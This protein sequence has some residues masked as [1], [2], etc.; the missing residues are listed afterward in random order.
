MEKFS[1]KSL[2]ALGD[3]YVYGLID[4][5]DKKLF[6][7]GK[8][9]GNRV[10]N[11]EKESKTS[12]VSDKLKL[13]KITEIIESG[14]EVEK[15]IIN[16][17]LTE[18][19]AYAAEAALINAFNYVSNIGLTNISSGHHSTEAMTVERFERE[20]GAEILSESDI[21]HKI[22]VI[23]INKLYDRN[24]TREE[25]YDAVRGSWN[26]SLMRAKQVDYVFG[27]FNSL[28]VGVYKPTQW[29]VCKDAIDKLPRQE[30]GLNDRIKNRIFFVDEAF[31][32]G[33]PMDEAEMSYL[34][35]SISELKYNQKSQNPITY[36]NPL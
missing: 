7:I 18:A 4:P 5:R 31:E 11:H 10:F 20:Y 1:E 32:N 9:T 12:P 16:S 24:M 3:Y 27:V 15:I 28:I 33:E 30:D 34:Y 25:L 23:K 36:L 35:K 2:L 19:E 8:G 17:N 21:K 26:A 22:L 14:Y 29:Y 13:K 6:Y